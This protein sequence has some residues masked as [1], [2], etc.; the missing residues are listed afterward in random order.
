MPRHSWEEKEV[1]PWDPVGNSQPE[2]GLRPTDGAERKKP[3]IE[4]IPREQVRDW[5]RRHFKGLS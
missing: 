2:T 5:N 4:N 3:M 1:K